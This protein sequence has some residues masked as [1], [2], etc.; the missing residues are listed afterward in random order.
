MTII[1]SA[2][3][4]ENEISDDDEQ[5]VIELVAGDSGMQLRI[6]LKDS[7]CSD[8]NQPIDIDDITTWD[9]LDLTDAS[10]VTLYF[11]MDS[12]S[13]V[14][15][16]HCSIV[17]PATDGVCICNFP[18]G[19][20]DDKSGTATG[21]VEVRFSNGRIITVNELYLFSIRKDLSG[22]G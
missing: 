4:T 9:P 18:P 8:A 6:W 15:G 7:D 21:E 13:A 20:L 22:N 11:K 3:A 5:E 14:D 17:L 19:F 1:H 12:L 10:V 16:L 2:F